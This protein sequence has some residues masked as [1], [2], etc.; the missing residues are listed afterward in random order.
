MGETSPFYYA[1]AFFPHW[2]NLV[3]GAVFSANQERQIRIL[4]QEVVPSVIG[5]SVNQSLECV[6][7]A[8]GNRF[9]NPKYP[10]EQV[11]KWA[12]VSTL[13]YYGNPRPTPTLESKSN[14]SIVKA[15]N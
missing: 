15:R 4:S 6:F 3:S 7:K 5:Y 13:Y 12:G 11:P 14:S 1:L 10:E 9:F 2:L 8:A